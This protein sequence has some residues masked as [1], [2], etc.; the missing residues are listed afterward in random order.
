LPYVPKPIDNSD[1]ELSKQLEPLI[2]RLAENIHEL[3]AKGRIAEGWTPGTR[4]DDAKRETPWLISYSELPESEKQYDRTMAVE[5]LKSIVHLGGQIE[6]PRSTDASGSLHDGLGRWVPGRRPPGS[7]AEYRDLGNRA[8]EIGESLFAFDIANE[9]LG[10]WKADPALLQ[11]KALALARMGSAEQAR[12]L[13]SALA[14]AGD[15][16]A[17]GISARTFKDLWLRT[18]DISD[19]RQARD[20]YLDAYQSRPDHYWT[21]INAATL[22]WALGEAEKAVAL[23][24][25]ISADCVARLPAPGP[26]ATGNANY[27][28]RATLA[29]AD[30]VLAAS[31]GTEAS[32]LRWRNVENL[33]GQARAVAGD[34]FGNVFSTW[35]NARIILR[36]LPAVIGERIEQ[37]FQV[38]RVAVF[39]GHRM[40]TPERTQPR[41]PPEIADKVKQ[42]IKDHLRRVNVG[43]GFAMPAAGSD[44]LFL[45][46]VSELGGKIHI[47]TPCDEAQFLAE[48]VADAGE[49]WV[50]R[51]HAL[52]EKAEEV[53]VASEEK[54]VMGG[55]S[56]QYAADVLDGLAAI[57]ARQYGTGSS[58]VAV[59]N[60]LP[61]DGPGGTCDAVER[62]R[63][64]GAQVH[65]IN[66]LRFAGGPPHAAAAVAASA[67]SAPESRQTGAE[68]DAGVRAM[69]FADV[70]H[71]SRLTE[72][73]MPV[74]LRGFISPLAQLLASL[75]PAPEFQNT[76]GDGFFFVFRTVG[77]A[78]RFALRL[79]DAVNGI[80]RAALGL[81]E[82]M[83]LR[84]AIHAGP[85][86]RFMDQIIGKHNFM[87]SHVN[88]AAR[89]E[90]VTVPGRIYATEAFAA[91]ATLQA[92][93]QF[94]FDYVGKVP[95][96]KDFGRFALYDV[97]L[98]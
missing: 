19:L 32:D 23:A 80:D 31:A 95:L 45:E 26:P 42:A 21:G 6:P 76:W 91:L 47:V 81:P 20:N 59:W 66:P 50:G 67:Q 49:E 15:E 34:N 22:S 10:F 92:P 4:R 12:N 35:R 86:F 73:Q 3:W 39:A 30:L 93:G 79:R 69:I 13:L 54:V 25:R 58:H 24:G 37:A 33:Y 90:P 2:E 65:I 29:E 89:I 38:P 55:L 94:R 43:V 53:I 16:E 61:G 27:W 56:F 68:I 77:D 84:I 75:N 11:I 40:D 17:A 48:S 51:Y 64:T 83:H 28:L 9:G 1:T 71:F 88:R 52:M 8:N 97:S 41:F 63:S 70:R 5:T 44:I 14:G 60:E 85:V 82:D 18:G 36:Q 57:R 72:G 96:A 78:G 87:G 46:A 98:E 62:W 7:Y 74:F